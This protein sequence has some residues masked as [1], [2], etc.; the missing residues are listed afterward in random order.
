MQNERPKTSQK[1]VDKRK[2]AKLR[3]KSYQY[4]KKAKQ[5]KMLDTKSN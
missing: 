5:N 2:R 4:V 3:K 1:K